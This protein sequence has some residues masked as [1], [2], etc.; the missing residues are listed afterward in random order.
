ML[1]ALKSKIKELG[2]KASK[3]ILDTL[4]SPLSEK[5]IL[6]LTYYKLLSSPHL[7]T[8]LMVGLAIIVFYI[9][10]GIYCFFKRLV[11]GKD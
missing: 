2:F 8:R 3:R 10:D 5:E 6:Y 7:F 11:Y 4:L 1:E 9:E